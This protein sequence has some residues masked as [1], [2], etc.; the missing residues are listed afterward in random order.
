MRIL[1]IAED[2][3]RV[4]GGIEHHADILHRKFQEEGIEALKI[5]YAELLHYK[6][7]F[8]N[9]DVLI[10]EGIKRLSLFFLY[11]FRRD[12][13]RNTLLFTHGSLIVNT[14]WKSL[15]ATGFYNYWIPFWKFFDL[16]WLG[17]I[18]KT[19]RKII[20]LSTIEKDE[21]AFKFS[22]S[23]EDI[24]V[25]DNFVSD[26][27][28]NMAESDKNKIRPSILQVISEYSPYL[29][30]V[31]RVDKRKNLANAVLATHSL[32]IN[33]LLAGRDQG[34]LKEIL[35]IVKKRNITTFKYLGEVT[36]FERTVLL[37]NSKGFILPSYLEGIPFSI[38]EAL[39]LG[40]H[41]VLF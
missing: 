22:I 10:F 17:K 9:N 25:L 15:K 4:R 8:P 32:K 23:K 20:T 26:N 29:L 21:I 2:L 16:L 35:K 19:I 13:L 40:K 5:S 34:G 12:L 11:I 6:K 36:D 30:T 24:L 37:K 14:R 41:S 27:I 38:Y 33:Y 39:S 18:L 31:S 3:S 1:I 28:E 7:A